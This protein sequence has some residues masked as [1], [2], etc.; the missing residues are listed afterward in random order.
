MPFTLS[1][2]AAVLPL[3]WLGV[4]MS[5]LVAGSMSPDWPVFIGAWG[6]YHFTHSW[7]GVFLLDWVVAVAAVAVWFAWLRS[8]LVD[9][10][11]D[12]VRRRLAPTVTISRRGWLLMPLGAVVGSAIHLL[13]DELVHP[14]AWGASHIRWIGEMHGG[15]AG[16]T[17]A[18]A[19][20]DVVG[21]AVVLV[22]L[23]VHI[24]RQSAG[25]SSPRVLRGDVAPWV[26]ALAG[27]VAVAATVTQSSGGLVNLAFHLAVNGVAAACAFG[28]AVIVAW[29]VASR[30]RSR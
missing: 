8:P 4:P 2:P 22:W 16:T 30:A 1:H 29:Q 26:L 23:V 27:A 5:A 11:P 18:Q 9:L 28:V 24:A 3:R 25:A 12:F 6:A 15:V 17:W 19:V 10:S 20:S 21:L 7:A 14:D 13:W